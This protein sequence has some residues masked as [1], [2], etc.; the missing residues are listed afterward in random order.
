MELEELR[1]MVIAVSSMVRKGSTEYIVISN[2]LRMTKTFKGESF[3][4]YG[5]QGNSI[6][7]GKISKGSIELIKYDPLFFKDKHIIYDVLVELQ[8]RI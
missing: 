4:R 1:R 2:K 3:I 5:T 6:V 8:S 7:I